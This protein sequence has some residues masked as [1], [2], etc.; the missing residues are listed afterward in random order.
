LG[1][2]VTEAI[3]FKAIAVSYTCKYEKCGKQIA[4]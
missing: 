2:V 3:G 4:E 1:M